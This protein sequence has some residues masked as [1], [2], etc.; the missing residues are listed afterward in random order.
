MNKNIYKPETPSSVKAM[1]AQKL[2]REIEF[3]HF[4]KQRLHKQFALIGP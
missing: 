2:P 1:I 3:Y 4:C